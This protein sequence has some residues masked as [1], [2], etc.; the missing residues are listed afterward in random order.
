ML[1]QCRQDAP[2][3]FVERRANVHHSE[4]K[5]QGEWELADPGEEAA[6]G[7]GGKV[8]LNVW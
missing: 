5:S 8:A 6:L 2:L 3:R 7:L 4:A 1:V